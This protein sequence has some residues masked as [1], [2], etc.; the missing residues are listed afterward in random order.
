MNGRETI[1]P[2]VTTPKIN[3]KKKAQ[4]WESLILKINNFLSIISVSVT[5]HQVYLVFVDE[6]WIFLKSGCK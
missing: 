4:P 1:I 6:F 2:D 5:S 3:K